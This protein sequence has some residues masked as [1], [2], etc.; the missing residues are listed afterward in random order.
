[1]LLNRITYAF[2]LFT[3]I[4]KALAMQEK[5]ASP[6]IELIKKTAASI[7]AQKP[8]EHPTIWERRTQNVPKLGKVPTNYQA[9]PSA[10]PPLLKRDPTEW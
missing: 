10:N 3:L 2:L 6:G 7:E 1:M 8:Q 9:P 4:N 5:K